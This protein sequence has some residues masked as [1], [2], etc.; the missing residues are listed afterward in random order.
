[1][2][3]TLL[4]LATLMVSAP[5]SPITYPNSSPPAAHDPWVLPGVD[6]MAGFPILTTPTKTV[7]D[8]HEEACLTMCDA[9]LPRFHPQVRRCKLDCGAASQRRRRDR[10]QAEEG[11][12]DH[13]NCRCWIRDRFILDASVVPEGRATSCQS[14]LGIA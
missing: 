4:A 6:G 10:Q 5:A 11:A 14:T 2:K 1:M 13:M 9:S 7:V 8:E 3:L 12:V